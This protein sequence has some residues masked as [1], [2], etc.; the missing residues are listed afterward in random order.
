MWGSVTKFKDTNTS[1]SK[2]D[3]K[4]FISDNIENLKSAASCEKFIPEDVIAINLNIDQS[5]ALNNS[6]S[7]DILVTFYLILER[8]NRKEV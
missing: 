6:L 5:Q 3:Y 8:R 7:Y 4:L 2:V 1:V